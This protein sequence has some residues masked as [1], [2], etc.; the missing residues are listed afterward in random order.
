MSTESRFSEDLPRAEGPNARQALRRR[1][2]SNRAGTG[3]FSSV[4]LCLAGWLLLAGVA[5]AQTADPSGTR[6]MAARVDARIR[7]LQREADR[8]AS[9]ARS[10]LNDMRRLEIERDLAAQQLAQAEAAV[11]ATSADL[12]D[13]TRRVDALERQRVASLP[14]LKGRFVELYKHGRGGYAQ[15]LMGVRDLREFGRASRAVASL[16]HINRMR[17]EEHRRTLDRLRTERG[18]VERKARDLQANQAAAGKARAAAERAVAARSALIDRIDRRRDLNAQLAGELQVARAQLERALND[19]GAGHPAE[20]VAVPL[21]PFRGALEWPVSG[22]VVGRYGESDRMAATGVRNGVEIA[23]PEGTAVQ[24][25]HPGTVGFA[26]TFSGYGTLVILDHGGN[27]Y[28]LY[29]YLS[30]AS[31]ARGAHVNAGDELGRVGSAPAG[32]TALYYEMRVDGRSV[33]PLQWLKKR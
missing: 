22:L 33:N 17:I 10:L 18:L 20:A 24:A 8:L 6:Q 19:I 15:M 25:V 3:F 27:Q 9:Q 16:A 28:S 1:G 14:D 30:S 31:V 5:G 26:D 21:A 2:L 11:A 32:D 13:V 7:T 29:G 4:S 23:A 12:Q